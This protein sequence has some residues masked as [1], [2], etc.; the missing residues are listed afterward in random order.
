MENKKHIYSTSIEQ[1]VK[2]IIVGISNTIISF[3][4]YAVFRYLFQKLQLF[5]KEYIIASVLSFLLS[6]LWSYY[7]NNKFTFKKVENE[8]RIVW[9]TI[10]KIY[11]AYSFASLL[12]NNVLLFVFVEEYNIS[13]DIAYLMC[14]VITIPINYFL[15]KFWAFKS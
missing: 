5:E 10:L 11:V 6:V 13:K 15:N 3:L 9:K 2:F 1:F 14:I 4:L 7:W 12:L 8:F